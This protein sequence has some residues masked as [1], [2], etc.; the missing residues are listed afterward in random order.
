MFYPAN[1]FMRP[2]SGH[3]NLDGQTMTALGTARGQNG[4]ATTSARANE[5]TM[6]ALATNDG[7]LIGTFHVGDSPE[8]EFNKGRRS[9]AENP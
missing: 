6:S 3:A 2:A 4:T 9:A 7:R 8:F 5:E 1:V